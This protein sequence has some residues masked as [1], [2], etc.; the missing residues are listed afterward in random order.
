METILEKLLA[1]PSLQTAQ[2]AGAA[3]RNVLAR[4]PRRAY[5]GLAAWSEH[6]DPFVRIASGVG[7]GLLGTRDRN[8]LPEALRYIERLANDRAADVREHGAS[9]ALEQLWLVH[10]DAVSTTVEQWI[11]GKNDSVREV[12]VRTISRIATSGQIS[13]PSILR[14]FVERGLSV[15]DRLVATATPQLRTAIAECVD[16]MGCL[17]P[18]LVT[19]VVLDWAARDDAGALRTVAEVARRPFAGT[20]QGLDVTAVAGKLKRIEAEA[21]TRAAR[22]VREGVGGVD[23][24]PLV[25]TRLLEP[26]KDQALP[27]THVADP[28]RGCQLRCEFCHSRSLAEWA[29]DT[30]ETFVRRV[31]VVQNVPEVLPRE[32]ADPSMSPRAERVLCVGAYADPYQPAEERFEA[33]R[34]VLKACLEAEHPVVVQTRQTL[35][36]RDLDVLEALAERGLV[37]VLM[38]MQTAVDGIRGKIELGTATV[39]ERYR[40]MRMLAT[41]HVPVGLLLSPVMPDLT[42]DEAMLDETIRRAGDAGAKWVVLQ[43]LDLRGSAGVKVRLFLENFIAALGPKYDQLYPADG[44]GRIADEAYV[45]RITE[46][47][48]RLAAAHAMDDVSHML[49]AGRDPRSC[50]VRQ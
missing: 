40:A 31:S 13:R 37:N 19:P 35:V 18:D 28:Y 23:Y 30:P 6:G 38:S 33:T 36:L 7:Y 43:I 4:D 5:A 20:C 34:E 22:W 9:A 39:A 12:V 3:V 14:R 11:A 48:A 8:A 25:A 47:V 2:M 16:E 49:T 50:L 1:R 10:T 44:K 26:A 29:G 41:K 46:T 27:W 42:D 32:L 45:Q 17:A 15:Y 24:L 21:R